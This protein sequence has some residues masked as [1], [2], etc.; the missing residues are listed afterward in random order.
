MILFSIDA[1]F[2]W[3]ST[4]KRLK[5]KFGDNVQLKGA[6]FYTVIRALQIRRSRLPKPQV[7]RGQYPS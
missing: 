5:A 6:P 1:W 4:K 3:R 2:L 7:K